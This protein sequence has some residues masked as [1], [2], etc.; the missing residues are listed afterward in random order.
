MNIAYIV[1]TRLQSSRLPEKP[2]I[3]ILGK[4]MILHVI[5]R[6]ASVVSKELIF[7]ATD[8]NKIA[9][10]VS[11]YGFSVIQ[12]GNHPTGTD[13]IAEANEQ[14]QAKYVINVQGDEPA[15]NPADIISARDF[16]LGNQFG[17][18]T[19]F[20]RLTDGAE[21]S[22]PNTIKLV[23]SNSGK[24][25]YI[26]RAQIPGSKIPTVTSPTYRQV[27]IYGYTRESLSTFLH[28]NRSPLEVSEDH[29]LLRFVENDIPV[30]VVE[31]TDWSIP[32]DV[33]SDIEA[34]ENQLRKKF[35]F[36]L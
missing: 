33:I 9:N 34:V 6:I 23:F 11:N 18:I 27:C 19:G 2:L 4:E 30:G 3:K 15:F 1:P 5:D 10:V 24:L 29:E 32:V 20:S 16:L 31:L 22:D 36:D 12:T 28:L 8:S 25:L 7:V 14:L 17:V 26:S 35:M 13:R 21:F